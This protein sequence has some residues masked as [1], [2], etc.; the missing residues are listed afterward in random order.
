[1]RVSKL[2]FQYFVENLR[3]ARALARL[4]GYL[5]D[6]VFYGRS[7]PIGAFTSFPIQFTRFLGIDGKL[8]VIER[9]L[10]RQLSVKLGERYMTKIQEEIDAVFEPYSSK[11]QTIF[12]DLGLVMNQT[13]PEQALVLGVS[14][15]E[16]YLREITVSIIALNP[17][18]RRKFHKEIERGLSREKLEEYKEDAKR[19]Q[20]EIVAESVGL[21][22]NRFKSLLGRI[23]GQQSVFLDEQEERWYV[24]ITERR[25]I[26]V[27]RA[28]LI[29]PKF[30]KATGYRG[31][32]GRPIIVKRRSTLRSLAL[33]MALAY[34]IET[35]FHRDV[36]VPGWQD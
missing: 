36:D 2:P 29:D 10:H 26:I 12:K 6:I 16:V 24:K 28:G 32:I 4:D 35:R 9:R 3:R 30:R 23:I 13:L 27:H 31:A 22:L 20:G 1:M 19:T 25:N 18:V 11:I 5:E 21:E 34:R 17:S 14:A 15:F 7:S 33:L 8:R